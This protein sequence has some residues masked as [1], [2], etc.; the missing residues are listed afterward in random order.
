MN[1]PTFQ[2]EFKFLIKPHSLLFV[3]LFNMHPLVLIYFQSP[4]FI[5]QFPISLPSNMLSKTQFVGDVLCPVNSSW[6]YK[7]LLA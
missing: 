4:Q 5:F 3:N 1:P 6:C 7:M 2:G